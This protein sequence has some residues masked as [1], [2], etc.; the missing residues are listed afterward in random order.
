MLAL[1]LSTP[2]QQTQGVAASSVEV[3][4]DNISF[5]LCFH[6]INNATPIVA[7]AERVSIGTLLKLP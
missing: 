7:V 5:F 1:P 4:N 2:P 6:I 3:D